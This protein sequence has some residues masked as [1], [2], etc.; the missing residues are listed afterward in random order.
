MVVKKL[1]FSIF[2][3]FKLLTLKIK[4][5]KIQNIIFIIK[6]LIYKNAE[7]TTNQTETA[8]ITISL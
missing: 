1:F 5:K 4:F 2:R 7:T 3:Y 6:Q 8:Q